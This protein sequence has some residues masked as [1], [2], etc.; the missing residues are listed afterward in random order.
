MAA[1]P[2]GCLNNIWC[3]PARPRR[4]GIESPRKI[5]LSMRSITSA[6]SMPMLEVT[7]ARATISRRKERPS[8]NRRQLPHRCGRSRTAPATCLRVLILMVMEANPARPQVGFFSRVS[9]RPHVKP[10]GAAMCAGQT[11]VVTAEGGW[12]VNLSVILGTH[13]LKLRSLK[14]GNV[15]D[16]VKFGR[17]AK[18]RAPARVGRRRFRLTP[19]PAVLLLF[20]A[21]ILG[22]HAW[23]NSSRLA[24][25]VG[26]PASTSTSFGMCGP[27][28]RYNCVIDGDTF[29]LAS[30]PS[31]P[32][33]CHVGS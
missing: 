8:P 19:L 17:R 30:R 10:T 31:G 14:G 27:S 13:A 12:P 29:Y 6:L 22:Y 3:W 1:M 28:G 26:S 21:L 23:H 11:A 7:R 25:W 20:A 24:L 18:R 33:C 15:A 9:A 5:T 16:I 4:P 2:T 32:S